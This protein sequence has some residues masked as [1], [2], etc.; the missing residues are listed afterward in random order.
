MGDEI[1]ASPDP[2]DSEDGSSGAS[3]QRRFAQYALVAV[4]LLG[5]ALFALV[6]QAIVARFFGAGVRSD[7]LFMARDITE[8][9]GNTLLT[10]QAAGVLLPMFLGIHARSAERAWKELSA[11]I[12]AAVVIAT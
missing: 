12:F 7:S 5:S 4:M 9:A 11:L 10:G 3:V 8:L 2:R 6:A 1:P